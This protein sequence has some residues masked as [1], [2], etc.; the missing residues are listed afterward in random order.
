MQE[1]KS[2]E[3][4]PKTTHVFDSFSL[5]SFS[6]FRVVIVEVVFAL[7]RQANYVDVNFFSILQT[8]TNRKYK[9]KHKVDG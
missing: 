1:K 5:H 4:K 2:K 8:K 6:L 3:T 7:R 9:G